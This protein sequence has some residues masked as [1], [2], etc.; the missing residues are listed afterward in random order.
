MPIITTDNLTKYEIVKY[1]GKGG[2]GVVWEVKR[3]SDG[4]K[5]AFKF[6]EESTDL[7]MRLAHTQ[8]RKNIDHLI[9]KP[10]KESDG[11]YLSGFV[12]P[13]EMVSNAGGK[14]GFGYIMDFVEVQKYATIYRSWRKR[15]QFGVDALE[16]CVLGKKI[17]HTFDRIH[18][19]GRG[20]K[21][22]S[23][24]NLC[25]EP[26]T[27]KIFV[28]DCDNVSAGNVKSVFGT[29]KYV[30]PEVYKTEMPDSISDRYSMAVF[31]YRLLVGGYPL[32][33]QKTA[34]YVIKNG[35]ND[36]DVRVAKVLFGDIAIFAFDEKDNSNR[37]VNVSESCIP[38]N[39]LDTWK[40]QAYCWSILP[41]KLKAMFQ[42]VFSENLKGEGKDRRPTE[43]QWISLFDDV[44]QN[45]IVKCK[46]GRHN[47][48]GAGQC[49]FCGK[50]LP[51]PPPPKKI[52]S[53]NAVKYKTK[54]G[55]EFYT[56]KLDG[57]D[58]S[59]VFNK[60]QIILE[61]VLY[62]ESKKMMKI[63]NKSGCRIN[64]TYP[65][66][67]KSY[68]VHSASAFLMIGTEIEIETPKST[69]KLKVTDFNV[70]KP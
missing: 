61:S 43:N 47:F 36:E 18:A 42:R 59:A 24:G 55:K 34:A 52:I 63:K 62:S 9:K 26:S 11:S 14:K 12:R 56:D 21:D 57:S 53:P 65:T 27:G 58:I 45:D 29:P 30:A 48:V 50:K 5:F 3:V 22:V 35:L 40:V 38:Q 60:G 17:A 49:L 20:Y 68:C 13:L 4:A 67:T 32:E 23:E 39:E 19:S 6:F 51:A 33:G 41:D 25:F 66:G 69:I 28:M 54:A 2:F 7:K 64:L 70:K 31:F 8:I 44:I 1:I 15:D 46:C 16:A 37:I 10:I